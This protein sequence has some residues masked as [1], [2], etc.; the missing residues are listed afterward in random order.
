MLETFG[1]TNFVEICLIN[2]MSP[3]DALIVLF[4]LLPAAT[5]SPPA[6][7][8]SFECWAWWFQGIY[9]RTASSPPDT[10]EEELFSNLQQWINWGRRSAPSEREPLSGS[11]LNLQ[12][13]CFHH[14]RAFVFVIVWC[15]IISA[16]AIKTVS[17]NWFLSPSWFLLIK[18]AFSP[19]FN[20]L[21][22]RDYL[23]N[24]RFPDAATAA[25]VDNKAILW[26]CQA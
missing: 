19:D 12:T 6:S 21:I 1:F 5:P 2:A 9:K 16:N 14:L 8:I 24:Q 4:P 15:L 26:P 3:F 22:I 10:N 25:V 7:C 17:N 13:I 18:M 20:A 23:Q 11:K